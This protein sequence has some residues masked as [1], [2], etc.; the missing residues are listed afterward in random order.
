VQNIVIY[1]LM[2]LKGTPLAS[3]AFQDRYAHDIRHRVVPRQF[4]LVNGRKVIDSE[5]VIVAT[6]T[7]SFDDYIELRRLCF[8]I[9]AFFSSVELVPL[10]RLLVEN[11][12]DI[13]K[14]VFNAQ[15]TAGGVS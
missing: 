5:E 11:G 1:T 8:T 12:M 4:S 10:K 14:W 6:N 13:A 2:N 7:M 9:T 3:R 15:C